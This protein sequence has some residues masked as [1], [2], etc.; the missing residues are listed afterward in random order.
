MLR[1]NCL[2]DESWY[3]QFGQ[4]WDTP[5]GTYVYRDSGPDCKVLAVAHRDSVK[6]ASHFWYEEVENDALIMSP[7]LDDRLGCYIITDYL[8]KALGGWKYDL[9]LTT[10][11]ES[12][13]TTARYFK[14]PDGKKYN[15]VFSF[16]RAGVDVVMYKYHDKAMEDLMANWTFKVARGS[17][18]CIASLDLG[19]KG[20]NFGCGY[21][22]YHSEDSWTSV[23]MVRW[24]LRKFIPFFNAMSG[25]HLEHKEY[26]Y[27]SYSYSA[28]KTETW[29]VK[30]GVWQKQT[31]QA[32]LAPTKSQATEEYEPPVGLELYDPQRPEWD[33]VWSAEY[34]YLWNEGIAPEELTRSEL[35]IVKTTKR[36]PTELV[37]RRVTTRSAYWE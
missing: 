31:Y 29:M 18:S 15:W 33:W 25:V 3:E 28:P 5:N 30:G 14:Q 26:T 6:D 36:V 8:P 24:N 35:E 23:N 7:T 34:S 22:D 27:A 1:E 10:G 9:L 32:P 16:D 21:Q 11:E 12:G 19:C 4:V 17:F 37:I 20:M 13:Q 2:A